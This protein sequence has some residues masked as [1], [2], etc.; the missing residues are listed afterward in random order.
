ME[1][2][3]TSTPDTI[4]TRRPLPGT[5]AAARPEPHL[6]AVA[7]RLIDEGMTSESAADRIVA[8]ASDPGEI[9]Q[10]SIYFQQRMGSVRASDDG[11]R[12]NRIQAAL[13]TAYAST[14]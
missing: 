4:V 2:A 3:V 9:K 7:R 14:R 12:S 10:A 1:A 11:Y 5:L 8:E 6:V 13:E